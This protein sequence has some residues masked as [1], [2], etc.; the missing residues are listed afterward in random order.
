MRKQRALAREKDDIERVNRIND[1]IDERAK[2]LAD[3]IKR[4]KQ[5]D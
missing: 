3:E 1:K 5:K 2:K 4:L